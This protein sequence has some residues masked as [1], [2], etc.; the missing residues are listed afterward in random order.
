M[1]EIK[2]NKTYRH[3]KGNYYRVL[4]IAY[5]AENDK[6]G[7]LPKVVVYKSNHDD[8]IFVRGY[9]NFA[10]KVDKKKYPNADQEYR[11]EE[12]D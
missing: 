3:F 9:D 4:F 1:R 7:I 5:D 11:F 10:S 6:D 12:V 2:E 8:R